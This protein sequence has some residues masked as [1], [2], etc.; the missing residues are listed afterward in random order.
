MRVICSKVAAHGL[1]HRRLVAR[2]ALYTDPRLTAYALHAAASDE[3]R[4]SFYEELAR[5]LGTIPSRATPLVGGGFDAKLGARR[6]DEERWN[7]T[8]TGPEIMQAAG[9]E[10]VEDNRDRFVRLISERGIW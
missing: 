6:T 9:S 1:R 3:E 2:R 4:E 7:G 8:H 5:A 10:H